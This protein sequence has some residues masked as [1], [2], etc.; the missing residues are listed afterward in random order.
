MMLK[1]ELNLLA[2]E[3]SYKKQMNIKKIYVNRA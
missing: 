2:H 1:E 3:G